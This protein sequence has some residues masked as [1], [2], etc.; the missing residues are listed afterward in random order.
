MSN[1]KH[2]SF[3]EQVE[4]LES[5]G[6]I[7]EDKEKAARKL[8]F[9][10]YYKLKELAYPFS[11]KVDDEIVYEDI[12]FSSLI[13]RY[14]QDKRLR[15]AILSCVEK[16]EVAF[17]T[18]FSHVMGE[19]YGPYGYL[20]FDKWCNKEKYCKYYISEKG[21][22]FRNMLEDNKH[23][24]KTKC[25][26]DHFD[27]QK[28]LVDGTRKIPVWMLVEA[29]TFGEML[30]LFEYMSQNNR[31]KISSKFKCTPNELQSW[32]NGLKYLRNQCAH[33]SNVIDLRLKTRPKLREEW[34]NYINFDTSKK[35]TIGGVAELIIIMVHL[36]I[37]INEMYQFNDLQKTINRIVDGN[38]DN[39]LKLGFS[40]S[41]M[42]SN[43]IRE[44]G[45]HFKS[46]QR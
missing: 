28:K 26:Q 35:Q 19:K 12:T 20:Q 21:E 7:I 11:Y 3:Y 6:M 13:T 37:L 41:R 43:F 10:S 2:R 1:Y 42:A 32:L 4:L 46:V 14:Y 45:G 9:I 23:L 33:N 36:T 44:M 40:D 31:E 25:I 15:S 27:K 8:E 30:V 18:R 17:K 38:K 22:H 34:L 29:L 5:R 39:A 16:I 24:Y